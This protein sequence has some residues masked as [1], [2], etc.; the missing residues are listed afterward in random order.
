MFL[1]ALAAA[2]L[3][4]VVSGTVS[5]LYSRDDLT[6]GLKD[7]APHSSTGRRRGHARDVLVVCQ[8]AF[9]FVLLI[10]AGLMLR[11]FA[12]LSQ[13]DP[14]FVPQ[15]VLAMRV[16]LNWSKYNEQEQTR[17][18]SNR[19]LDKIRSLPG[20]LSA[21]ISTSYPMDPNA[22]SFGGWNAR[23]TIEGQPLRE[24]E[25]PPLPA[26][27]IASPDYFK[28][29]GIPLVKGRIFEESD[30]EKTTGVAVINRALARHCWKDSDPMGQR[31]LLEGADQWLTVVGIVGDVKEFGLNKDA[32]DEL[33]LSQAQQPA[34]G[35]ILVRTSQ[36]GMSLANQMRR[37]V[38]DVD[39]QTAIP[40]VE[41][42]EQARSDSM[43][44]PRVMTDLL[45]I[46]AGLALAIAAFGI[47]G[48][49]ALTVNQ[50]LNEIGIRVALGAKPGD[51]LAM[52]IGQGMLLVGIGL[53]IG[54]A[55]AFALTRMMK[56]LLFQVGPTDPATF[57][58]VFL[59]LA[60]SALLACYVPAR[61]ALRIDPLLAL[62]RE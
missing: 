42:L 55:S 36:D 15:R 57:V 56:T 16:Y 31:I 30:N 11:S 43:A 10:G 6:E 41:T 50:R 40:N 53:A 49:L 61:R 48:I 33:Y 38:L 54:L 52:I 37:A 13:V 4:A 20:V 19:I 27:R 58:G 7:G 51:V 34:V 24:G 28:T 29:L 47:G 3:T 59:V 1:F 39:P 17:A 14:G 18:F 5:A 12:K 62:R 60:L 35:A 9:S 2:L 21:A 45:G 25:R 46:F 26:I 23:M 8:V 32:G 22:I 44:S